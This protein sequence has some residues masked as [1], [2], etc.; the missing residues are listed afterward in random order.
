[1]SR[2]AT[3]I[4]SRVAQVAIIDTHESD[5]YL[6]KLAAYIAKLDNTFFKGETPK[7]IDKNRKSYRV[8]K[9]DNYKRT[10]VKSF[11]ESKLLDAVNFATKYFR[12]VNHPIINPKYRVDEKITKPGRPV[13][14]PVKVKN[15]KTGVV[16]DSIK[17]AAE[18]E[19]VSY[20]ILWN[21]LSGI[22]EN[23]SDFRKQEAAT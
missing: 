13:R 9:Y 8:L 3:L 23:K 2:K 14:I 18:V 20:N 1:M 6:E 19:G 7:H 17:E 4:R 21:M 15:I 12:N 10:F 5:E 22:S 16:F 11:P